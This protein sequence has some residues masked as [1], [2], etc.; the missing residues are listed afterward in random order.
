MC[1]ADHYPVLKGLEIECL[2][3]TMPVRTQ[4]LNQELTVNGQQIAA[5]NEARIRIRKRQ[6]PP[7][8]HVKR[9]ELY[10]GPPPRGRFNETRDS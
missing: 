3:V 4:S 1:P 8:A 7:S 10:L 2:N 6:N 9:E 5:K